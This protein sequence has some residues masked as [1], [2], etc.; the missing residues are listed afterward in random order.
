MS[1][2]NFTIGNKQSEEEAISEIIH[3]AC[4]GIGTEQV[5]KK[6]MSQILSRI[7]KTFADSTDPKMHYWLGIGWRN[8]T[9]WH[10]KGDERTQYLLKAKASFEKAM[11]LAKASLPV[12]L[13]PKQRSN[14]E[15]LD[16]VTIVSDLAFLLVKNYLIRDMEHAEKLLKF[17]YENS[18]DYEP[19]LCSYAEI[20]AG[21]D[22]YVNSAKIASELIRRA[23]SSPE[24]KHSVPP[25]P[26]GIA[27]YSY[28]NLAEQ[29]KENGDI[30]NAIKYMEQVID[31]GMSK[32]EDK[33]TL[34]EL[35]SGK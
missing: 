4:F 29:A 34:K 6:R 23:E 28:R 35:K 27:T 30:Q 32:E 3:V 17:V 22:D 12:K 14:S 25:A 13:P 15:F 26:I 31:L 9:A 19:C 7:D 2:F 8:F 33:K 24:W 18:D 11:G 21:K 20:F 1:I 5:G 16:Q 10:I